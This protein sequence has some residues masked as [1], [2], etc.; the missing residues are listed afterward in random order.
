MKNKDFMIFETAVRKYVGIYKKSQKGY[1][2]LFFFTDKIK[3]RQ[4]FGQKIRKIFIML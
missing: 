1:F 2:F 3:K 4:K